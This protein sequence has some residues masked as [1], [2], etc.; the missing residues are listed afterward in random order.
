[1][2]GRNNKERTAA[3]LAYSAGDYAPRVVARGRGAVADAIISLAREHG[4]YVH[5]SRELTE[6]LMQSELDHYIPPELYR[7]VAEILAWLYSLEQQPAHKPHT[8][9]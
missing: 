3:A 1:M 4:V 8:S 5:H 6:Q 2:K 9:P 7:S